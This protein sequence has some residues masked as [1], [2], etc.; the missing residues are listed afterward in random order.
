MKQTSY[1]QQ[2]HLMQ[3]QI[4]QGHEIR[5]LQNQLEEMLEQ[6]TRYDNQLQQRLQQY[7]E[8]VEKVKN[9]NYNSKQKIQ[10]SYAVEEMIKK[11]QDHQKE[12]KK[13]KSEI[14]DF[15]NQKIDSLTQIQYD[16]VLQRM[17]K[18]NKSHVDV[19]KDLFKQYDEQRVKLEQIQEQKNEE[20]QLSLEEYVQ[21]SKINQEEIEKIS[22]LKHDIKAIDDQIL[23]QNQQEYKN[24]QIKEYNKKAYEM[25]QQ[26]QLENLLLQDAEKEINE[27][28]LKKIDIQP[29]IQVQF[30]IL[31][32]EEQ[33]LLNSQQMLLKE[34]NDQIQN[35]RTFKILTNVIIILVILIVSK[36]FIPSSLF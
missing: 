7:Y 12:I 15:K 1:L 34:Q 31:L 20:K 13:Q 35:N 33:N 11:L 22:K 25:E 2:N 21:L 36:C 23:K 32:R 17:E 3:I 26:E 9:L 6:A 30:Q 18:L 8:S 10:N 14:E 16:F 24:L 4:E 19:C 27:L 29:K 5:M 28:E